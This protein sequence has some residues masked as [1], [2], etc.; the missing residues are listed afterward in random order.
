[1]NNIILVSL[2]CASTAF[3]APDFDASL[4]S[5]RRTLSD[6]VKADTTNP[7]GNEERAVKIIAARLKAEKIPFEITEFAPGRQN[8]V[9]RLKGSG[10]EKPVLLLAHIDVVG[11]KDQNWSV[12]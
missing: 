8:I 12:P 5:F 1:M 2:M 3:A 4:K 7:P 9:A 10:L 6:L 11:V